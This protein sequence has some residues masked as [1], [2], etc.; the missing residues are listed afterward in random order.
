MID[1]L[2]KPISNT[3][4]EGIMWERLLDFYMILEEDNLLKHEIDFKDRP[5]NS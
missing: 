4:D 1:N 3:E 2:S 5:M